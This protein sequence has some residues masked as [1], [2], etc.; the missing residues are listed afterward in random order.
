M[1]GYKVL[2]AGRVR[3]QDT[4]PQVFKRLKAKDGICVGVFPKKNI[5]EIRE[6]VA[7]TKQLSKTE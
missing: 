4:L 3:P 5:N 1:V 7:L 6:N 2:G